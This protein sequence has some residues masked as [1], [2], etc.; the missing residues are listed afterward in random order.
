PTG[1]S[2]R[3]NISTSIYYLLAG[4]DFSAFHRIK[5]DEIW[6]F[7]TGT[8][9][10]E[11][12]S[13]EEGKIRK[14]YLGVNPRENQFFQI[15]VPKNTWFAARLVN[16]QGFALAGCTVSP[17]FHFDDFEMANQ[18]LIGQFPGIEKEIVGLIRL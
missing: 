11:I 8:S 9:A 10:I 2:G 1:F 7:Y 14:Q 13:V 18:K 15:V 6:H 4:D 17:G 5:S 3:R 16:K 12:I